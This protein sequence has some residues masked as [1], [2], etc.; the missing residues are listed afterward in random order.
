MSTRR[1]EGF[2]CCVDVAGRFRGSADPVSGP[3]FAD[4]VGDS[5]AEF[6]EMGECRFGFF[7]MT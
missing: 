1:L 5:L 6:T 4:G 3:G 7:E 2:L